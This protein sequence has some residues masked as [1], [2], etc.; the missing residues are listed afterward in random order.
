MSPALDILSAMY[1]NATLIVASTCSA[2]YMYYEIH[3]YYVRRCSY[4]M[5]SLASVGIICFF[6]L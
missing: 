1:G 6:V 3:D 4:N 5:S 2:I